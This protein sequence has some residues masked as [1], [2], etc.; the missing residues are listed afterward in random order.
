MYHFNSSNPPL[1]S[2]GAASETEMNISLLSA[3]LNTE[4][5]LPLVGRRQR[6]LSMAVS[7]SLAP[8][9]D[10]VSLRELASRETTVAYWG[11]YQT[12]D[13]M[14]ASPYYMRIDLPSVSDSTSQSVSSQNPPSEGYP[15]TISSSNTPA[16]STSTESRESIQNQDLT[17]HTVLPVPKHYLRNLSQNQRDFLY[18]Y[19]IGRRYQPGRE[20][21]RRVEETLAMIGE[22]TE[23]QE[24]RMNEADTGLNISDSP[25]GSR[26]HADH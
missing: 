15:V 6:A 13:R 17:I 14:R 16:R 5:S 22:V 1:T 9:L 8:S 4:S 18:G 19:L 23:E 20:L 2:I 7:R 3:A 12:L 21:L 25:A 24:T 10:L 26:C 11:P